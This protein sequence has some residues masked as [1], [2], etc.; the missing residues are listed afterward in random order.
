M[1]ILITGFEPFN[2]ETINPSYEAV[3][4]LENKI[5]GAGIIKLSLPVVFGK[6]LEKLL[7]TIG[8]ERPDAV[9]CVGQAGG[10]YGIA[11]ERAAINMMDSALADNEGR[12]YEEEVIFP[13][14]ENA[15]FTNLPVKNMV[16]E[17]R[18][19]GIPA[20]VSNSAG[21]YV[22]NHVMYGL[23]YHINKRHPNMKG[24]FIHVPYI[25]EQVIGKPGKAS[26]SLADIVKGITC[27]IQA[28]LKDN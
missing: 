15:Y 11:V 14:G 19:N 1:K 12:I 6:S 18:D 5:A 21:T 10:N 23:L 7:E 24:G 28:V 8:A 20:F 3:K 25:P 9:I 2:G 22:C 17:M 16:T 26:M 13:D 27:A 4:L